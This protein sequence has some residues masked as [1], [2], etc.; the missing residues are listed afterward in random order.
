VGDVH[1]CLN[2]LFQLL[3]TLDFKYGYD[4][5]L[6]TGDLV[7]KGPRSQEVTRCT[8]PYTSATQETP[9]AK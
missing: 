8:V 9:S 4:N 3:D 5:L 6:L 7:N 1:G 2:E